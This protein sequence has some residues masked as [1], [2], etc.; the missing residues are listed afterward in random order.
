MLETRLAREQDC[1]PMVTLAKEFH[2]EAGTGLTWSA[3][4]AACSCLEFVKNENCDILLLEKDGKVIGMMAL[5]AV[6]SHLYPIIICQ[7]SI[8]WI[9]KNHRSATA[10]RMMINEAC[11]WAKEKKCSKIGMV[12][13][14]DTMSPFYSRM[15]FV[16]SESWWW[17]DL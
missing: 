4:Y 5:S 10:A 6:R 9:S 15:K 12:D 1:I 3:S 2:D 11:L 16:K 7:E 14:L 8:W 13:L 17:R